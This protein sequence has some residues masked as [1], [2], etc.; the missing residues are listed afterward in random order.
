VRY[1][2]IMLRQFRSIILYY[3]PLLVWS[4][5][6]NFLIAVANYN[7]FYALVIKLFLIG[8]LWYILKERQIRK[9]LRFY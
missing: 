7:V 3:K 1:I 4:F 6:I 9:K 2:F 8:L 5:V